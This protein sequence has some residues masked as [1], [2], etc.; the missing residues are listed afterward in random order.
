VRV[1]A[2]P[3]GIVRVIRPEGVKGAIVEVHGV[4]VAVI[5]VVHALDEGRG[6]VGHALADLHVGQEGQAAVGAD[7]GKDLRLDVVGVVAAVIPG[8][9]DVPR[10]LVQGDHG[11]ELAVTGVV[12]VDADRGAPGA[13]SPILVGVGYVDVGV[14]GRPGRPVQVDQ[15]HPA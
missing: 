14:Q 10:G 5:E 1:V 7:R 8:D 11:Q 13:G 6:G 15:V 9:G 4:E 2:Q 12:V 3:R